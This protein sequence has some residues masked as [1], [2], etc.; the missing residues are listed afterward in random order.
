MLCR[1]HLCAN[2]QADK[3]QRQARG[4]LWPCRE[5]AHLLRRLRAA[6]AAL[7]ATSGKSAA[8]W[9][10]LTVC[11]LC[12]TT[13]G[14][15]HAMPRAKP[16]AAIR[17]QVK[18]RT[19]K[20]QYLCVRAAPSYRAHFQHLQEQAAVLHEVGHCSPAATHPGPPARQ[21]AADWC[22]PHHCS[23]RRSAHSCCPWSRQPGELRCSD[24]RLQDKPCFAALQLLNT[25]WQVMTLTCRLRAGGARPGPQ[26]RRQR[27][28]HPGAG[29]CTPD[30]CKGARLCSRCCTCL[31]FSCNL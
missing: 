18:L 9:R 10:S 25:P 26:A 31:H 2:R 11:P 8:L 13:A 29:N 5:L 21:A 30:A 4:H 27:G 3:G 20:A 14:L 12:S 7:P 24:G 1:H 16:E 22:R 17:V 19:E 15:E 28:P 23:R 6:G